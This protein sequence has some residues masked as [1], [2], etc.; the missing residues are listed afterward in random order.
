M[1]A[2]ISAIWYNS[3][4]TNDQEIG[5]VEEIQNLWKLLSKVKMIKFIQ[6]VID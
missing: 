5:K 2:K 3:L 4:P 6:N 1:I